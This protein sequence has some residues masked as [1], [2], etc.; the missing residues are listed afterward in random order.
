VGFVRGDVECD[1]V[2]AVDQGHEPGDL[3]AHI[4]RE[5]SLAVL[6]TT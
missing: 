2:D 4:V 5:L 3:F 1:D 6:G